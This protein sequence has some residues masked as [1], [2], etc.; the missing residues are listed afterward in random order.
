MTSASDQTL[1]D[2]V[3]AAAGDDERLPCTRAFAL[4]DELGV[5]VAEVGRA[6]NE[7]GVKIVGCQLGCF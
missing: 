3:R 4:A 7:L 6:C 1:L 2:A 5:K